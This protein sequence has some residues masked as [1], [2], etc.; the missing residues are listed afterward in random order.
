MS[1][2]EWVLGPGRVLKLGRPRLMAILNV[3]PDS[4]ADGGRLKSPDQVADAAARAVDEGA[5]LVDVGGESTRPGSARV[6]AEEQIRR[7]VPSIEAIRRRVAA[8]VLISVDTT[9]APVAA[10]AL[11]AGA[12]AIND[13]A[14]GREDAGMF[15]L[16]A[17]RGCGLVLMHRLAPPEADSYSTQYQAPPEYHDVVAEVGAFLRARAEAAT[18]AGVRKESIVLD[19]GLGFGKTV[20]QNLALITGTTHLA[21]I[22]FPILSALSRKS[23]TGAAGGLGRDSV[24]ADRLAATLALSVTHRACGAS[25]FRVHDVAHHMQALLAAEAAQKARAG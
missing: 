4:F 5:D 13:V 11:D 21:A 12:D 24:P 16:A 23:F 7:V 25:I 20:Q 15:A 19:P 10:A 8:D 2:L 3:T 17:A 22:G 18:A 9:L 6:P 1:P 14:A